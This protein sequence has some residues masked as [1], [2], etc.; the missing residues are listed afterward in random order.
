VK[1]LR[2]A[3]CNVDGVRGRKLELEHFLSQHGV[4]ICLLTETHLRER[5]SFGLKTVC[6]RTDRPTEGGGTAIMVRRGIDHYAVPV[7]GL[8][9]LEATA[10]H[11]MLASGTL[12]I[13]AVYLSPSRPIVGSGLSA[14]FGEGFPILM[15]GDV[16]AKHVDWHSRLATTRCK[17]LRYYDSGNFCL[18]YGPDSPTTV[19]YNSSATPD[20]LD[21]V[22]TKDLTF[23]MYL[24]AC[25]ALSSDHLPVL[26]DKTCRSSFPNLPARPDY[27]R[28]DWVKFQASLEERLPSPALLPNEGKIDTCV[29]EMSSAILEA[30]AASTP[31]SR[32]CHDPRPPIPARTQ[33]EIRLKNRL[34]RQWQITRDPAP[35]AKV[36]LFSGL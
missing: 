33:D 9:Q 11:I 8:T 23:P 6:H 17:L 32:P 24:T 34:R 5:E 27:R 4:D 1:A 25:S 31:K 10:V 12:K 29:E 26:F 15:T 21:I 28:T 2:L 30:L 19:P 14:C 16:N 7:L 36:N 3:C 35:K 20:V 18:M 22:I 13:L